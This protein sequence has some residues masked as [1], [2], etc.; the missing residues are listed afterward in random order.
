[1]SEHMETVGMNRTNQTPANI[2]V[3]F[4]NNTG[5]VDFKVVVY[6]K[7]L[8]VQQSSSN[9]LMA[10]KVLSTGSS[11]DFL[12]PSCLQVGVDWRGK[13]VGPRQDARLGNTWSITQNDPSQDVLLSVCGETGMLFR[14]CASTL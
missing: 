8:I 3:K 9:T 2:K 12:Y 6:S 10:W 11:C 13:V 4:V 5:R 1:M 7:P 14:V